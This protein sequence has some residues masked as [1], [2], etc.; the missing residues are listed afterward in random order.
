[1]SYWELIKLQVNG[2][3]IQNR[4][5]N[6]FLL[7]KIKTNTDLLWLFKYVLSNQ[8]SLRSCVCKCI[9]D[10]IG[11]MHVTGTIIYSGKAVL[12]NLRNSDESIDFKTFTLHMHATANN[13]DLK[14]MA[15]KPRSFTLIIFFFVIYYEKFY[16]IDDLGNFPFMFL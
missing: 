2:E 8:R 4:R 13:I 3:Q 11:L 10:S 6:S 14:R 15:W 16:L 7:S 9:C 5:I 1:M 12:G